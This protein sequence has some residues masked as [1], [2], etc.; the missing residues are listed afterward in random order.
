MKV[1]LFIGA[2]FFIFVFQ[3]SY[4]QIPTTI[5]YQGVLKNADGTIVKDGNYNL[6]FN[7]YE[8]ETGGTAVWAERQSVSVTDGI[9]N[10]IL[11]SV[12]PLTIP[13]NKQYWL[14]ISV[15][16]GSE[17]TPRTKLTSVPYSLS[18]RSIPDNIVTTGKIVRSAVTPEKISPSGAVLGQSLIFNGKIVVWGAPSGTGFD[19]PYSGTISSE[20]NAFSITNSGTGGAGYFNIDNTK[21]EN[22]A[23]YSTT[24]GAGRAGY[25][26]INNP[27]NSN[28]ALYVSTNGYGSAINGRNYGLGEAGY[29]GIFNLKNG[30]P[31]LYAT[32]NG[33]GDAGYF[34]G[35]LT[36]TKIIQSTSGGFKFP[37]GTIQI[38]AAT[39]GEGLTLPYSG[40]ASSS[41]TLFS[42]TNSG[43]GSVGYFSISDSRNSSNVISATTTGTGRAGYFQINNTGNRSD[44]LY[45]TTNGAGRAGSFTINNP[46]NPLSA[47]YLNTNGSGS[48]ITGRNSGTGHGGYFY[49]SN[50]DNKNNSLYATTAGMG[51]AGYFEISNSKNANSAIYATT[52]GTGAAG[53][54]DG[55]VTATNIIESTSGGFKFPDKTVQTSAASSFTLPYTGSTSSSNTLFSIINSGSGS[56][57]YFR[58]LNTKSNSDVIF[59]TT[60]GTGRAGYFGGKVTATDTIESTSGGFKFPDR[61]VQT[62]AASNFTL[63]YTDTYSGSGYAFSITNSGTGSAVYAYTNTGRAIYARSADGYAGYFESAG[64]TA[65]HAKGGVYAGYFDGNVSVIGNLSVTGKVSKGS[66]SFLIDHPLD[67]ENKVLR[68]SFVESPDMM[69]IYKGRTKLKDGAAVIKLPD[70]FDALNHPEGREINLTPVNGWSPLFLEGEIKN[71]QFLVKTT[72][73]GNQDQEFSWVIYANRN[74]EY[75]KKHPIIVEEEKGVNNTF[76]KGEYIHPDVYD[77]N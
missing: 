17:L 19:L 8:L 7:L 70:Y 73:D 36:A 46:D 39:G 67:P 43:A 53:Y 58:I 41:N 60:T 13:F 20:K 69:N 54:F 29:F 24:N 23:L 77:K 10:V 37:D 62:T 45:V 48:A 25:F 56:A 52:N 68:H 64:T 6:T 40:T 4:A 74:D 50:T 65:I 11:G 5:S 63:P 75:A 44:A 2:L 3:I 14:G 47:L 27:E 71:N 15:N 30:D 32:T 55:K 76:T 42:I 35:T 38:T 51:R 31:A 26:T 18:T 33:T 72:K 16:E 57:G 12:E 1:K 21:N 28:S 66:G 22:P 34:E 49:I 9:F 59:A 61:T